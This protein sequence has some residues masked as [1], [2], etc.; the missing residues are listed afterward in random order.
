MRR[1]TLVDGMVVEALR[2][3][4]ASIGESGSSLCWLGWIFFPRFTVAFCSIPYAGTNPVL[5]ILA[6]LVALF[7]EGFEKS[8]VASGSKDQKG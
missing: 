7:G 6:W 8:T 1:K 4:R 3:W 5:V 2:Y